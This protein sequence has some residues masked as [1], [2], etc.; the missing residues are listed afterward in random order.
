MAAESLISITAKEPHVADL[1]TFYLVCL[2]Q[3]IEYRSDDVTKN[4]FFEIMRN[5]VIF[6]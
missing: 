6:L 2:P 5:Y 4:I 1:Q 3:A